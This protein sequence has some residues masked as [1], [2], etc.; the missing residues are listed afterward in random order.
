M[1]TTS[2]FS[3]VSSKMPLPQCYKKIKLF[4]SG[5][6]LALIVLVLFT[7]IYQI[8]LS[9]KTNVRCMLLSLSQTSPGF[10]VSAVQV[11]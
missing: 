2:N 9:Q 1:L 4:V 6:S 10:Y 11:F 8:L 7:S 5:S 3:H